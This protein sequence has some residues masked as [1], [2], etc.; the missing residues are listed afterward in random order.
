MWIIC[1]PHK[2]GVGFGGAGWITCIPVLSD[3]G[4]KGRTPNPVCGAVA[5]GGGGAAAAAPLPTKVV[6][7]TLVS[8][9]SDPTDRSKVGP[10][11]GGGG[12]T[13][14][15]SSPSFGNCTPR[16][17]SCAIS[18]VSTRPGR[19]AL[20]LLLLTAVPVRAAVD[21][22]PRKIPPPALPRAGGG[23]AWPA[24]VVTGTTR[25]PPAPAFVRYCWP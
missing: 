22:G 3:A 18:S 1:V 12:P 15:S 20:M 24:P 13:Q 4:V 2:G 17:F 10:V 21:G 9:R 11:R 7:T 8:G 23:P 14:L 6:L 5:G 16:A 25:V 19:V